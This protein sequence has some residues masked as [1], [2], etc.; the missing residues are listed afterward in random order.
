MTISQFSLKDFKVSNNIPIHHCI[1]YVIKQTIFQK[2][3]FLKRILPSMNS[4][5][6][7]NKYRNYEKGKQKNFSFYNLSTVSPRYLLIL[8]YLLGDKDK[9]E[10]T[11][12]ERKKLGLVYYKPLS[13]ELAKLLSKSQ[14]NTLNIRDAI[15]TK[16][17]GLN[18]FDKI[19]EEIQ[20]DLKE[21]D[22]IAEQYL[23]S[24]KPDIITASYPTAPPVYSTA[25]PRRPEKVRVFSG[26]NHND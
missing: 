9:P 5:V 18:K 12:E 13:D 25:K 1:L 2:Y 10:L 8:G 14:S 3:F 16:D 24:A 21:L 23:T 11:T 6:N 4:P 15:P 17:A 22:V 20:N 19:K 26:N 7:C